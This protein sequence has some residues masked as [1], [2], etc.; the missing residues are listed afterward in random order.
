[1]VSILVLGLLMGACSPLSRVAERVSDTVDRLA[2]R[3][4][5]RDTQRV[6]VSNPQAVQQPTQAPPAQ[7]PA[8][9][10]LAALQGTLSQ[11][12]D[13]VN[14]SVVNIQV[15]ALANFQGDQIP[16]QQGLGSGFVWDTAGHIVTNNHVVDGAEEIQVTFADGRSV[17]GEVVGRDVNSDLA[18]LRVDLPADQLQPVQ[19]A[20]STQVRVGQL[21]IAIGN[22]F[23]LEGT[24]TLGI[25]SALGR[26]LPVESGFQGGAFYRIPDVIQTDA[27]INPGNS[28]GVLVN[29]LG[30]V[31]G[32]TAAIESSTG[33]N[34]GIGFAIPSAIVQRVVPALIEDGRFQYPWLGISGRDLTADLAE[35]AG[36]DPSQRGA[37]VIEVTAGGPADEAG[38]QGSDQETSVNGQSVPAGGDVITA[39]DGQPVDEF[40]DLVSY[41]VHSTEVGQ[42]ITLSIVRDGDPM[43]VQVTIQARPEGDQP[44]QAPETTLSGRAW[45]GITAGTLTP[46]L[47]QEM[48]LPEGQTGVLVEA[49]AEGGPAEAAGLQAEDVITA[50]DGQPVESFEELVLA[51]VEFEPGQAITLSVLRSGDPLEVEITLGERPASLP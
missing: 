8:S 25:I 41:L 49:T 18:V 40:D 13:K 3:V 27:P 47:A 9:G 42:T 7:V 17:S 45:M 11:I 51:L 34:A 50:V 37:L 15:A 19:V 44:V 10:E 14:P 26:S 33:S 24:M 6:P 31:V 21:A 48:G 23:G 29:D 38:L 39:I 5:E 20:D 35:A 30:Q 4:A 43:E 12:Y 22:P 36:L 1:L 32:V 16:V 46:S 28:G 2:E